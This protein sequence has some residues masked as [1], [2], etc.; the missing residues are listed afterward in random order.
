VTDPF[1]AFASENDSFEP[2]QIK[3]LKPFAGKR[4]TVLYICAR[5][6]AVATDK[7]SLKIRAVRKEALSTVIPASGII[8][9]PAM[10]IE[11]VGN[12]S[13]NYAMVLIHDQSKVYV[14]NADDSFPDDARATE[15][16]LRSFRSDD[17]E[18]LAEWTLSL[19]Q[20]EANAKASR[21]K[22]G[23][24]IPVDLSFN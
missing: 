13:V 21:L 5:K 3:G 4:V 10:D 19:K 18:Y 8:N 14:K 16:Q 24:P 7:S 20:L 1:T 6:T 2:L 17:F 22:A 12:Y 15:D 9:V 23:A 11:I